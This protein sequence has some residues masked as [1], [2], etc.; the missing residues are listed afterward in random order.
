MSKNP[1]TASLNPSNFNAK[2]LMLTVTMITL[3]FLTLIFLSFEIQ[4]FWRVLSE[5]IFITSGVKLADSFP[6]TLSVSDCLVLLG[7]QSS[8]VLFTQFTVKSIF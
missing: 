6:V 1:L 8:Q 2:E 3:R 7:C 5:L 4:S